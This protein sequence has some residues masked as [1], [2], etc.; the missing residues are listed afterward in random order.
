MAL[1]MLVLRVAQSR[2]KLII[3]PALIEHISTLYNMHISL[4]TLH[5][6]KDCVLHAM[7]NLRWASCCDTGVM[8]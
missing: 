2:M 4:N 6:L 3:N 7:A 8:A 1:C 5:G